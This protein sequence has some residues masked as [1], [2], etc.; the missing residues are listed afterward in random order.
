MKIVC[1]EYL[2]IF[3]TLHRFKQADTR[4][5]VI[6]TFTLPKDLKGLLC[7]LDFNFCAAGHIHIMILIFTEILGLRRSVRGRATS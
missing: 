1:T 5:K 7:R 2:Y 4:E 6:V 3:L